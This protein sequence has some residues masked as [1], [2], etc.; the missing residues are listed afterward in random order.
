[1]ILFFFI[2]ILVSLF[3][4]FFYFSF[5]IL[6]YFCQFSSCRESFQHPMDH[7]HIAIVLITML[8]IVLLPD[9]FLII[10]KSIWTQISL[11]RGMTLTL[12]PITRHGATSLISHGKLKLLKIMLHNFMNYTIRHIPSSMINHIPLNI[13]QLHIRNT[14]PNHLLRWVLTFKIRCWNLWAR[15]LK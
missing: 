13:K 1:L 9:N 5:V 6:F 14:K 2:L 4:I 11:N 7:V 15:W 8:E 10:L 12:I 3:F